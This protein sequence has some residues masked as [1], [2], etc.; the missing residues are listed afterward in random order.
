M[1]TL[2]TDNT[3]PL[4]L[5]TLRETWTEQKAQGAD[6]FLKMYFCCHFGYAFFREK[7]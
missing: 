4:Q 6:L 2:L 3:M 7:L 1:E 5:Q